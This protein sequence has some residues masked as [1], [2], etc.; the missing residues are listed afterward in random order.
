MLQANEIRSTTMQ[1]RQCISFL[2][3]DEQEKSKVGNSGI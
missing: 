2:G 3:R 1:Q